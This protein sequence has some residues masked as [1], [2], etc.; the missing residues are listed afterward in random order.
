MLISAL[1][2]LGADFEKI[3]EKLS[4]VAD[5]SVRDVK[6]LGVKAKKFDA[7]FRVG[8]RRYIDLDREI[9]DLNVSEK[10][11]I[12][13]RNILREL[14]I[15]EARVH[16]KDINEVHLHDAIDCVVDAVAVALA[17]EDLKLIDK[18]IYCSVVSV[19]KL[20]P[21]T[22]EIIR[23]NSIPIKFISDKEITTPTGVAILSNIVTEFK[24]VELVGREGYGAGNMDLK[25]PNVLRA[26]LGREMVLLESNVD[27]CSPE[28]I[29]YLMERIMDEGALDIHVVPVIMK[30]GRLGHLI[31]ILTDDPEKFSRILME[32][33]GTLGV[34]VLPISY[35]F[36][37]DREIREIKIKIHGNEEKISIK[38]SRYGEKPEFDDVRRIAKKYGIK[39]RDV[40]KEF[41]SEKT[42]DS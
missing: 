22:L 32:E 1:I 6:K 12:L 15:S 2:D 4:G 21:A 20:A 28:I 13:A 42:R 40:L 41:Y 19:G 27:D 17:L 38:K 7:K 29:S 9:Q 14:A 37:A 39:Y 25:R 23:K 16:N 34:R 26:I 24:E 35:R 18:E 36:E 10:T 33:T 3:R 31:R 30:K 11:K 8:K 5:L